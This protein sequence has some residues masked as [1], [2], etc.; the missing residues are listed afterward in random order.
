MK[1]P[2]LADFPDPADVRAEIFIYWIRLCSIVGRV[3]KQLA[4]RTETSPFPVHLATELIEWAQSL[5]DH[6]QLRFT[7][8]VATSFNRDLHQLHL[9][10]LTCITLLYLSSSAQPLPKAYT[11]A[12]L[13]ASC[14]SCI[15]EEYL[16]RG[17]LRFLNG[18]A[19]WYIT[20]AI[21]ALL[22]ARKVPDLAVAA[23]EHI[24]VLQASHREMA[25]LWHS[26]RM[27]LIGFEKLLGEN[28]SG[29][30]AGAAQGEDERT[31]AGPSTVHTDSG[32]TLE[33]L[34]KDD[35]INYLE[36]F[37]GMST[38][39]SQLFDILLSQNLPMDFPDLGLSKDLSMQLYDLY[40]QPFEGFDC[41]MFTL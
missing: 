36:Y 28:S 18:L 29:H 10:Y 24:R 15:F 22:H 5:P 31:P 9:P 27:F 13:S 3:G 23:D 6:L 34:T 37:P 25:K 17:S 26:S 21:L 14:V 41:D 1:E 20:V 30:P 7:S 11:A 19:G 33:D 35:G 40:A 16:A 2:T 12:I 38:Y 8:D 32:S 39:P 4:R